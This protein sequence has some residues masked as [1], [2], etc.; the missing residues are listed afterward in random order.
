MYKLV[1]IAEIS[2]VITQTFSHI[3]SIRYIKAYLP[4]FGYISADSGMFRVLEQW[5]IFIYIKTHS[6]HMAYSGIF[7]TIDIF[8]QFR[9]SRAIYAYSEPYFGRF[10]HIQNFGLFKHVMFHAYS[11]IFTKLQSW[12]HLSRNICPHW[13]NFSRF[14][15]IQ[16]PYI[17]GP[18]SVETNTCSSS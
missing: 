6:E 10:R 16:D 1:A 15:H 8:S 13:A 17:I 3:H 2:H 5:D 4:I 7:E 11:G 14:R 9:Y 12:L 18:N